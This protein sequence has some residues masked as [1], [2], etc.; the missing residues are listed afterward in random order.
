[1]ATATLPAANGAALTAQ[2]RASVLTKMAAKY[3]LERAE[4]F[5]A[6]KATA[7]SGKGTN[8]EFIAFLVVADQYGL[9]PFTREIFAFPKQGG[10][11]QNVVS[12]DGW[13]NIIN[14]HPQMDGAQFDDIF[15]DGGDLIA[16]KCTIFRKDRTHATECTEY[17]AECKRGGNTPWATWPRRMLRH[18]ALIQCARYAF[19]FSGIVD[20]DE[21]ERGETVPTVTATGGATV[22]AKAKPSP[23]NLLL[24]PPKTDVQP[25]VEADD[26]YDAEPEPAQPGAMSADE[27]TLAGFEQLLE[28]TDSTLKCESTCERAIK[29]HPHL[30]QQFTALRDKRVAAIKDGRGERSNGK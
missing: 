3:N 27:M 2:Q 4:L 26:V 18:K 13:C 25:Q 23:A 1:M 6:V 20:Q 15:G 19:G 29:D 12:V 11:I 22:H 5:D 24:N 9:N 7:F 28:A 14:S 16:V 10:G 8:E 17:M 21:Y 30:E